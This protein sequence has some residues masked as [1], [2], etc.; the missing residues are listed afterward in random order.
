[1]F[2]EVARKKLKIE[3]IFFYRPPTGALAKVK[4]LTY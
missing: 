1:M 4:D 3:S 2:F